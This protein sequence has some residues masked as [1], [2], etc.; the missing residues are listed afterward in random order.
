ML[1][2]YIWKLPSGVYC[3]VAHNVEQAQLQLIEVEQTRIKKA[4]STSSDKTYLLDKFAE[5]LVLLGP[6]Y[7]LDI[8]LGAAIVV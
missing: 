2:L 7:A 8:E 4:Y 3:A 5:L 1:K 6:D